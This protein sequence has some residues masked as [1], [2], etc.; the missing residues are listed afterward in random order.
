[1]ESNYKIVEFTWCD[2]CKYKN[3]A[4]NQDP[5]YDCLQEPVNIDSRRPVY[6]ESKNEG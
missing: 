1:M 3:Q 5:C 6:F 4:E 2:E